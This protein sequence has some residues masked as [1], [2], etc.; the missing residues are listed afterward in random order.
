VTVGTN[1]DKTGYAL[2]SAGLDTIT[3]ETGINGRQGLAVIYD[4]CSQAITG[5]GTSTVTVKSPSGATRI[6]A[7]MSGLDRASTVVTPPA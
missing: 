4:A 3:L 2:S 5:N 1:E 7:T 6:V